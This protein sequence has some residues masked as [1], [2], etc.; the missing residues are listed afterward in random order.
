M[1]NAQILLNMIHQ[2]INGLAAVRSKIGQFRTITLQPQNQL[3]A[4]SAKTKQFS[5]GIVS[6]GSNPGV[7]T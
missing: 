2:L 4:P 5:D 1:E 7:R 3:S 6:T